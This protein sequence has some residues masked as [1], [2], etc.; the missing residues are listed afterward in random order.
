MEHKANLFLIR[1]LNTCVALSLP[2]VIIFSVTF[3]FAFNATFY[4]AEFER[5]ALDQYVGIEMDDM[6]LVAGELIRYIKGE[7]GDLEAVDVE[8][9]GSQKSFF[10]EREKAHMADVVSLFQQVKNLRNGLGLLILGVFLLGG[11]RKIPWPGFLK[12]VSTGG[13]LCLLISALIIVLSFMDFSRYF[14]MFHHLTFNN[15][16]WLLDPETDLLI[17][18]LPLEFFIDMVKQI[19]IGSSIIGSA[20]VGVSLWAMRKIK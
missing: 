19:L 20:A 7:R 8:I 2:L 5:Y 9:G 12:A 1:I 13:F 6:N 17:R 15:E 10:N 16:L 14:T 11:F 18:M 4:S 3:F